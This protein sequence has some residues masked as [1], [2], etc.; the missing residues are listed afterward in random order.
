MVGIDPATILHHPQRSGLTAGKEAA[1]TDL[2]NEPSGS[3]V[4]NSNLWEPL[5]VSTLE[6][7]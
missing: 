2:D 5:P 1:T 6:D 7:N 3:S 4:P